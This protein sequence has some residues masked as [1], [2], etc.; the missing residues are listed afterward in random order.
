MEVEKVK[1]QLTAFLVSLILLSNSGI[2]QETETRIWD[3]VQQIEF[4]SDE[5]PPNLYSAFT[6]DSQ[7]SILQYC[8]PANY[9]KDNNYPLILYVPGNHGNRGGNIKN[10]IDI[11]N[12]R[13]CIVASLPLFKADID[14]SEPSGGIVISLCDYPILSSAYKVI[15]EKLFQTIPNIDNRRSAMVGFSNGAIAVAVLVS[16]HDEY[17]LNKFQSFCLVDQGVF[18]LTDLHKSPT[19]ERRFLILVGDDEQDLGRELIIRGAKLVMDSFQ[20][21]GIDIESRVLENTD[22]LLT[23]ENSKKDIGNWIFEENISND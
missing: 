22:H 6:G 5:L 17:I 23:I 18:H 20:L 9:S 3:D 8:L 19:K 13:E 1:V 15:L 11:A 16:S 12:N 4:S 21:L 10:A 14:R 2:S 7:T